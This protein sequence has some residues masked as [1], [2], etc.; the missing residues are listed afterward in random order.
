MRKPQRLKNKPL[1]D[2]RVTDKTADFIGRGKH[3]R[4]ALQFEMPSQTKISLIVQILRFHYCL[5]KLVARP[6]S[7]V[8]RSIRQP[9]HLDEE[10]KRTIEY[11]ASGN[12]MGL[13]HLRG[14]TCAAY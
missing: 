1:S 10:L 2:D 3:T 5:I 9:P 12:V 8:S 13:R 6:E 4:T 14:G 11:P 7:I